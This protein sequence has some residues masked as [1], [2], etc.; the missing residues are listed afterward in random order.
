MLDVNVINAVL[1]EGITSISIKANNNAPQI[2]SPFFKIYTPFYFIRKLRVLTLH[3]LK[4]GDENSTTSGL[5]R[6]EI[7]L[8][9]LILCSSF[10]LV[11]PLY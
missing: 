6:L 9:S 4:V 8:L 10:L 3:P 5:N 7:Q 11:M 2:K 1:D